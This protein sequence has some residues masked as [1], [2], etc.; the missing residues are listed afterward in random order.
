MKINHRTINTI[1]S[2]MLA[3]CGMVSCV[4]DYRMITTINPDGSCL[5]EIYTQGNL[6]FL[7]GDME[8]NPY[9]FHVDT[10]WQIT[11]LDTSKKQEKY[12]MKIGKTVRNIGDFTANI[13]CD[14]VLKPLAAPIETLEKRFRWFYT[15]YTFKTVYP[16]I[17]DKIPISI[18]QYMSKDEQKVWFQE[19]FSAYWGMNGYELNDVLDMLEDKFF[20]WHLRNTYEIYL[21]TVS[22]LAGLSDTNLYVAQLPVVKDTLFQMINQKKDELL[23]SEDINEDINQKLDQ[24]FNT[25][26]FSDFYEENKQQIDEGYEER[27]PIGLFTKAIKYELIIPGKLIS[28]N[29]SLINQDTLTWNITAMR[30]VP[31]NYEL[32]AMSRTVHPWAFIVVVFF[33]ILSAYCLMKVKRW[34]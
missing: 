21:E 5:R 8:Y 29:T 11:P 22:S 28:A 1:V 26:Y 32:T 33:I 34:R 17:S 4:S 13:H 6:K 20:T 18:D 25:T 14:E 10:S 12:N 15:Y 24:Y 9:I 31:D 19:N 23:S 16:C 30:L 27:F 3:C 2:A 7:A